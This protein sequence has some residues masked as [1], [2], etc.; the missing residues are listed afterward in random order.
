MGEELE[1]VNYQVPSSSG[2]F[3][4]GQSKSQV[5][6][7]VS[8]SVLVA[9]QAQEAFSRQQPGEDPRLETLG[10]GDPDTEKFNALS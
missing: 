1:L 2:S 6:P 8:R 4:F 5:A 3:S 7:D 10:M 9:S